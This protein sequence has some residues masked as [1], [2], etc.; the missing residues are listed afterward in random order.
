MGKVKIL[1]Y[2]L[3]IPIIKRL[4]PSILRFLN[5]KVVENIL[6]FK[7]YLEL[8]SSIDREIFLHKK[9]ENDQIFFL[10]KIVDDHKFDYF[11]DIGSYI[12]FYALFV[13]NNTN[14]RNIYAFEPNQLN[15]SRLRT[16][17]DLNNSNIKIF[18]QACSEKNTI[19]KIWFTNKNKTGGSSVFFDSDIELKRYDKNKIFL[20]NVNLIKLDDKLFIKKLSI[21]AKIDT[22]RHE[23]SVLKGAANL[24]SNNKTYLQIEIFPELRDKVFLYLQENRFVLTHSIGNDFFFKNY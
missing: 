23:L 2:L 11:L 17:I 24:F 5:I 20:N 19:S 6:N 7:L 8:S 14:I 3:K 9:Y 21:L 13:E 22:E 12:G 18:N 15:Y 10:K 4:I 1:F 16:N